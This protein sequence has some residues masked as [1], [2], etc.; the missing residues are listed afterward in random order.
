MHEDYIM[1]HHWTDIVQKLKRQIE[2][3]NEIADRGLYPGE[4][5]H[6]SD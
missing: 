1:W 3:L 4:T 5:S 2:V 6:V